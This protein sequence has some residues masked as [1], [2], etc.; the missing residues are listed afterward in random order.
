[1]SHR[2]NC[3]VNAPQKG[4]MKKE[5]PDLHQWNSFKQLQAANDEYMASAIN[6]IWQDFLRISTMNSS[7][8]ESI[9]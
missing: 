7:K 2:G 6:G 3:W 9:R 4:H 5:L 8:R 1:M